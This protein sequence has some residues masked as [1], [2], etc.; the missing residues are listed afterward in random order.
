MAKSIHIKFYVLTKD[1]S[2]Y[3]VTPFFMP[4]LL[5]LPVAYCQIL[6]CVQLFNVPF[7]CSHRKESNYIKQCYFRDPYGI[8]ELKK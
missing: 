7:L 1:A 2:A 5:I 8:S 6:K 4:R 3:H